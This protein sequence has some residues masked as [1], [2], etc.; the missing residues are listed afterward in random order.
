MGPPSAPQTSREPEPDRQ[1]GSLPTTTTLALS[2]QTTTLAVY[3]S[4]PTPP[5]PS[6]EQPYLGAKIGTPT[7][8]PL[9]PTQIEG[10]RE[11]LVILETLQKVIEAI[12]AIYNNRE[13]IRQ[14]QRV[15]S[16]NK[17]VV[18]NTIERIGI[19]ARGLIE[20]CTQITQTIQ[21][22]LASQ[23]KGAMAS[24]APTAYTTG[25][26]SKPCIEDALIALHTTTQN[27]ENALLAATQKI[28]SQDGPT[29]NCN[30]LY[31]ILNALTSINMD[32][33]SI[34][35]KINPP[36]AKSTL[37]PAATSA[38]PQSDEARLEAVKVTIREQALKFGQL[39]PTPTGVVGAGYI[40]ERLQ[41]AI[42]IIQAAISGTNP[43]NALSLL[44]EIINEGCQQ[45]GPS[46]ELLKL[47]LAT[48]NTAPSTWET[49]CTDWKKWCQALDE[50]NVGL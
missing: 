36:P 26:E 17:N 31:A 20:L 38:E 44:R 30:P 15:E 11:V 7:E 6:P 25:R 41:R 27:L 8:E 35:G 34:L 32:L 1:K 4:H 46:V 48:R 47:I 43:E 19:Q 28:Q 22:L 21:R 24:T 10:C 33:K 14:S 49:T 29:I 23:S 13:D 16:L 40:R 42:R 45:R 37:T 50:F 39:K 5:I 9:S 12:S 18:T 2:P 3:S